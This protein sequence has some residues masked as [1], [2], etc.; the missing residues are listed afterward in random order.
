M[1]PAAKHWREYLS[2][3]E[4]C[5]LEGLEANVRSLDKK[6]R[7]LRAEIRLHRD[8]CMQRRRVAIRKA[9]EAALEAA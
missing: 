9:A 5:D 7:E 1:A 2:S 4:T 8:R 6:R 3:A